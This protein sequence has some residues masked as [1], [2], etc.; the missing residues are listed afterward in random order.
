MKNFLRLLILGALLLNSVS[1]YAFSQ[2]K[3]KAKK[4]EVRI[5]QRDIKKEVKKFE[6]D[7]FSVEPGNLPMSAQLQNS[8]DKI[9]EIDDDGIPKWIIAN[10]SSVAQ[11]QSAA[12]MQATEMAKN[13]LIGLIETHMKD[14]ITTDLSNNQLNAKDAASITKTIETA[15]NIVEKKLGR[16]LPLF[17]IYRKVGDNTEVQVELGYSYK[18]AMNLIVEEMKYQLKEETEDQ[19]KKFDSFLGADHYNKGSMDNSKI[20][21]TK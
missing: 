4:M 8:Y 15:T 6:K 10:G 1:P 3:D 11:T 9:R 21:E 18:M 2:T 19:R 7:G 17:K 13:R 16:V 12:E 5:K 20:E 14:V